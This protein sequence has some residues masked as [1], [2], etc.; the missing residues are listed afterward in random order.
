[1]IHVVQPVMFWPLAWYYRAIRFA[2]GATMLAIVLIVLAQVVARYAFSSSIIW[3]E[4]MCR[5]L[6]L[7]QTFL[8]IGYAYQRGEFVAVEVLPDLLT[9]SVRFALKAVLA[10]PVLIFLWFIMT[11]GYFYSQRFSNQI[12]PALD[13]IWNSLTGNRAAVSISY[14]YISVS[15][16]S[17]LLA[18]H[19]IGGLVGDLLALRNGGTPTDG[20]QIHETR[21]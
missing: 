8:V 10:V 12:I 13:F 21:A 3:A 1:M 5:Y 6:L 2:G 17:A 16:G 15:I 20:H 18:L 9:P 11:N 4:E 7:W 19:V 14:V